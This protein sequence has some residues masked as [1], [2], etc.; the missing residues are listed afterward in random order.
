MFIY[1]TL[2]GRIP[3]DTESINKFHRCKDCSQFFW[4]G[5][6]YDKMRQFID[7]VLG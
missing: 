4:K 2:A 5:S 6:H 1:G 7:R 3:K